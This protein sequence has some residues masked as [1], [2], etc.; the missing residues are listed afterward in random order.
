MVVGVIEMLTDGV[1]GDDEI[2]RLTCRNALTLRA[3]VTWIH[4]LLVPAMVGVPLTVPL[5]NSSERP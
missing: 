2:T 5:P 4:P 1:F 3:S